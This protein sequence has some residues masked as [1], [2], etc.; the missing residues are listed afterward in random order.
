VEPSV[1]VSDLSKVYATGVR[2][3]NGVSFEVLP[4]EIFAYLGRNGSGKTTTVRV[5]TT[6]SKPTG[7][8]VLVRGVD[9]VAN[10]RVTRG[11]IG[12]TLQ[13][14][15]LDPTMTGHEHLSFVLR[16]WGRG[17]RAAATEADELLSEFD[18]ASAGHHVIRT[19]SGGMQRRLDLAGAL[20]QR[21]RVL[22]LDEPTNGLDAQSRRALWRR[23]RDLRQHDVAVFLTTQYLEEAETLADRLAI[24]RE[25][26]IV[27]QGTADDVKAA[28]GQSRLRLKLARGYDASVLEPAITLSAPDPEEWVT[29]SAHI[30]ET[31]LASLNRL[32]QAGFDVQAFRFE[33][34]TLE[35]A[36]IG[37]TGQAVTEGKDVSEAAPA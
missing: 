1:V 21:P 6:L 17:R 16:C 26:Q 35:E 23:V 10:P 18:L 25:G 20:V 24:L 34:P 28:S 14:A 15:S 7:G 32:E 31:P 9:V 36:F 2:A 13:A 30:P 12:V 22:F 33:P 27:A 8:R 37:I 29:V 4:G 11:H 3:L 19:Y 5:L